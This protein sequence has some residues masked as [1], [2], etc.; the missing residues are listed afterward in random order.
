[1]LNVPPSYISGLTVR[2][3]GV[4]VKLDL[5]L[6]MDDAFLIWNKSPTHRRTKISSP[7]A[8]VSMKCQNLGSVSA[9]MAMS[10]TLPT[11]V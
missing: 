7:P 2:E 5:F 6:S 9:K 4:N 8:K 1:M 10:V 3:M 11:R